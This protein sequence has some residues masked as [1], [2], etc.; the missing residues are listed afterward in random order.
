M[1]ASDEH[2]IRERA[3]AAAAAIADDRH[4]REV[5]AAARP[6]LTPRCP[7]DPAGPNARRDCAIQNVADTKKVLADA[8]R[9]PADGPPDALRF[10][11]RP[12][13]SAPDGSPDAAVSR[14]AAG[15]SGRREG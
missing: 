2:A 6:V 15:W 8:L 13:G 3:R 4:R 11:A 1:P 5:D 14:A 9:R 7:D 12:E 10:G